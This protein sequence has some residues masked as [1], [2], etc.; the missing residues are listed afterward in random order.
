MAIGLLVMVSVVALFA[1][2]SGA[3]K[4]AEAQGRMNEDGQAALTILTQ[5]IRMTGSNPK[6]PNRT[7]LAPRNPVFGANT[8]QV[9]GCVGT[10]SNITTA[11]NIASLTTCGTSTLP[12]SIA[13]RYEAD[14]YNTVPTP[15]TL[16]ATDCLG[17]SLPIVA[18]TATVVVGTATAVQNVSFRVADNRFFIGTSTVVTSPSLYCKGNGTANAQPLVENIEDL[19]FTYGTSPA[20]T[21][22]GT[23]A[24][25][26][27]AN[28]VETDGNADSTGTSLS[29]LPTSAAR[30]AR[31]STVRIC[32]LA[33]SELPVATANANAKY[34]DCNG[35]LQ[36]P[37]DMRLR[38]A[39]HTTVVLRNRR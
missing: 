38:K 10:F 16:L 18:G 26:L 12:D 34:L 36:T 14:R 32:V 15:T 31:V 29:S 30:W 35:E 4:T 11:A 7:A 6:Q 20:G 5:Q 27:N 37:T 22:T 28:E 13:V 8:Y 23:V 21:A 1:G 19:K 3:G 9:R 33:R 39:Y 17:S 2:S 25:Y 24:G